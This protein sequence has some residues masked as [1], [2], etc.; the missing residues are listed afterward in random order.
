MVSLPSDELNNAGIYFFF[1]P[2]AR[3]KPE[4]VRLRAWNINQNVRA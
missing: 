1:V 3:K 2:E 4:A